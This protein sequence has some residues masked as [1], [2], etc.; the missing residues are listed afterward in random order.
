MFEFEVQK[1]LRNGHTLEDLKLEFFIT[2]HI[3]ESLGI[4]SVNYDQIHSDLTLEICRE[5]RGLIL[6]LNTW[7]IVA[8]SFKKFGNLGE[9]NTKD[10]EDKFNWNS[11]KFYDKIDGSMILM[12]FYQNDW[13]FATRSMPAAEGPL[14]DGNKTFYDLILKT[15]E[16]MNYTVKEFTSYFSPDYCYTFEITSPE[17]RVVCAFGDYLLTLLACWQLDTLEE[18]PLDS[19]A[20]IPCQ[21]VQEYNIKTLNDCLKL[22]ETFDPFNQQEGV[23]IVDNNFNRIKVKSLKYVLTHR[24]ISCSSTPRQQLELILSG[25]LDDTYALL[26]TVIQKEICALREGLNLLIKVTLADYEK[27]K[28]IEIQKDFALAIVKK[29]IWPAALFN[30]RKGLT[31]EAC[32]QKTTVDSLLEL[33]GKVQE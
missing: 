13:H 19:I 25:A 23:V 2:Y 20:N 30:V 31:I 8:R 10:I 1:Y 29:T 27:V 3:N 28:D 12:Y 18:I 24:A 15:I 14:G 9:S 33:I 26:P 5:S 16:K 11:I 17:N 22:I 7:N 32:V 4:V 21:K 6:E